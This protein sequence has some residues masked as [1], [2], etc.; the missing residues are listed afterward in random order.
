MEIVEVT[1]CGIGD[2]EMGDL[3]EIGE[4]MLENGR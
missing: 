1:G 3:L 2:G 4:I